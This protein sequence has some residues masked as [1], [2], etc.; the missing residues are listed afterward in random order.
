MVTRIESGLMMFFFFLNGKTCGFNDVFL[1][2]LWDVF[3][4][5]LLVVYKWWWIVNPWK[6]GEE[7]W[8]MTIHGIELSPNEKRW[9]P[10]AI[11]HSCGNPQWKYWGKH[12]TKVNNYVTNYQRVQTKSF[13]HK[14][15]TLGISPSMVI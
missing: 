15:T 11:E 9:Y 5:R 13:P 12:R 8:W 10:V 6:F 4:M 1:I 2:V 3:V 14:W 7:Q